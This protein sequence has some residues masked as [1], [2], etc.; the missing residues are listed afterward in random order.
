MQRPAGP[1][2]PPESG[3]SCV[4][5]RW[6]REARKA[7]EGAGGLTAAYHPRPPPELLLGLGLAAGPI[8]PHGKTAPRR[9]DESRTPTARLTQQELPGPGLPWHRNHPGCPRRPR[10][11]LGLP[12]V[13]FSPTAPASTVN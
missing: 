12:R 1:D 10:A 11:E 3:K 13:P 5:S 9:A 7:V 6:G 8:Y 2:L 4:R